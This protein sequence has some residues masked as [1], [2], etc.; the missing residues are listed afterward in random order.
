MRRAQVRERPQ[1]HHD[2]IGQVVV[3]ENRHLLERVVQRL[4]ALQL[5]EKVLDQP[6]VVVERPFLALHVFLVVVAFGELSVERA[7]QFGIPC[8]AQFA[9]GRVVVH[10]VAVRDDADDA[11]LDEFGVGIQVFECRQF[12][13]LGQLL[14]LLRIARDLHGEGQNLEIEVV[15]LI[16]GCHQR[17]FRGHHVV[18]ARLQ[19]GEQGLDDL[20]AE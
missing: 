18:G 7:D 6:P 9:C 15:G 19:V 12:L 4:A 3:P 17:L 16:Y 5:L 10:R 2:D 20:Y 8:P 1:D 14:T 13:L 11:V